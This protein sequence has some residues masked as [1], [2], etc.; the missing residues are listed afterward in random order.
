[1]ATSAPEPSPREKKSLTGRNIAIGCILAAVALGGLVVLVAFLILNLSGSM[2]TNRNGALP[3]GTPPSL[4]EFPWP[5]RASTYT[6][7]PP[8]YVFNTQGQTRLKD[9]AAR[10]ENALN[11]AGYKQRSYYGV[12][13]GFALVAQLEQFKPDG[14]PASDQYRWLLQIEPP[15][16]FT[17][18]YV[19]TL[20]KGKVGRYRLFVFAVS[21]D[22]FS[23]QSGK[24]VDSAQAYTL[25]IEGATTLPPA[26]GD[27]VIT[28]NYNCW[29]LV[30][31]F[32]KARLDKPAEFKETTV[33]PAET[34]L[35]TI[36]PYLKR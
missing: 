20:I 17:V 33:I 26:I 24:R 31:E 23:Q 2:T 27:R 9:V 29:A 11:S 13:N 6:K 7:L 32:E 15:R 18:D 10:L 34:H 1:V 19:S 8:R 30:Y 28:E 36:M 16:L 14:R 22:F 3:Q 5:P 35:Q 4:P 21:D 25:A 12:P